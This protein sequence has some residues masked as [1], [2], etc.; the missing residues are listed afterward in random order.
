MLSTV[1]KKTLDALQH[2]H[3]FIYIDD[4]TG[5]GACNTLENMKPTTYKQWSAVSIPL[6]QAYCCHSGVGKVSKKLYEG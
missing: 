5:V 2:I 6:N 4:I 1:V 3:D